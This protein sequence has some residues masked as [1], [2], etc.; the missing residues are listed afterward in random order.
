MSNVLKLL[1]EEAEALQAA[2]KLKES[3]VKWK[4]VPRVKESPYAA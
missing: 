2:G 3:L 1:F 4:G